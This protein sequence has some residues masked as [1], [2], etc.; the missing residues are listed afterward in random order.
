MVIGPGD[1]QDVPGS[2]SVALPF[3]SDEKITLLNEIE[4]GLTATGDPP[5]PISV[6]LEAT[7][8]GFAKSDQALPSAHAR[9]F[10]TH[11]SDE[12]LSSPVEGPASF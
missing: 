9:E 10:A 6:E 3:Q 8:P 1:Q 11:L 5:R 12:K 2:Q 7:R 4:A